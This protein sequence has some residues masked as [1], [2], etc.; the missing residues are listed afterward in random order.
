MTTLPD[1]WR[2]EELGSICRVYSGATPKTSVAEYW[3]NDVPW[4]TPADLARDRSQALSHGAR[5]LSWSG[6]RSCAAQLVPRGSVVVSSRAPIG[7]VAIAGAEL[8]TNQGCKT[9]APPG[10]LDSKYLYWYLVHS[11]PDLEARASGTT[12]KEISGKEFGR[13]VLRFPDLDK[14][15]QIVD[16]LED[17]LSRLD[18]AAT[19]LAAV[20]LR[21]DRLAQAAADELWTRSAAS[22]PS[23]RLSPD[24]PGCFREGSGSGFRAGLGVG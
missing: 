10:Y 16:T 17:H 22:A 13:T 1:G 18:A 11:K 2:A 5:G 19:D 7:Y 15:R 4:V 9:A 8:A 23:R 6:Y 3:G 20:R 24:P 14:Q 12:F 21:R